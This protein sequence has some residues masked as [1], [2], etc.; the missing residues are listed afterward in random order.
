MKL[1][2]S[3]REGLQA[4]AEREDTRLAKLDGMIKRLERI[5]GI[6]KSSRK[7]SRP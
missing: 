3:G 2:D 1:P 7:R 6:M 5:E 4:I